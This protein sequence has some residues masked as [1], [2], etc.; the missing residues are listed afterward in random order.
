MRVAVWSIW[1]RVRYWRLLLQTGF[2]SRARLDDPTAPPPPN[3][4][5]N[6]VYAMVHRRVLAEALAEASGVTL[7]AVDLPHAPA[8]LHDRSYQVALDDLRDTIVPR[9]ADEQAAVKAKGMA[10]L[11]KWWRAIERYGPG[12]AAAERAE[13]VAALDANFVTLADARAALRD[14]VHDGK[15]SDAA[16]LR[17]CHAGIV[18]DAALMADAMGSLADTHFAPLD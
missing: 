15:L 14:A 5:M 1:T 10:R 11:V 16:A 12:F 13:L 4:G 3:L 9:L 6:M 7:P 17:L 2:A 18:R 8:G